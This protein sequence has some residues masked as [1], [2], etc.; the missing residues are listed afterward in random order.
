MKQQELIALMH[1]LGLNRVIVRGDNVMA[2]CPNPEHD[3]NNPSWGIHVKEPHLHGCF[4]CGYK[5]TL[6][7]LLIDHNYSADKAAILA[8]IRFGQVTDR[9]LPVFRPQGSS[10][11]AHVLPEEMLYPFIDHVLLKA[12]LKKRGIC[13]LV[14]KQIGILYDFVD[15]RAIFPWR[16]GDDLMGVTGRTLDDDNKLK[17]KPYYSTQKGKILFIPNAVIEPNKPLILVEGEI[18]AIKVFQAGY[19]NVC[20]LGFGTFTKEQL[21]LVLKFNPSSVILFFDADS[22]GAK[23]VRHAKQLLNS[24]VKLSYVTYGKFYKA[25]IKLDPGMLTSEEIHYCLDETTTDLKSLILKSRG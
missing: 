21:N 5:G 7:T 8:G 4:G 10:D 13:R 12:F 11:K 14:A 9:K 15:N 19:K 3:D 6:Y 18:D 23:L 24:F 1:K 2:C 16:L 20:A 25:G 22:S 17:V